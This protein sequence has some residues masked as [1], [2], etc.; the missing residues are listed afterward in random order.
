MVETELTIQGKRFTSEIIIRI[1]QESALVSRSRLSRLVCEWVNWK[2]SDGRP[3]EVG[4][5]KALNKLSRQGLI[6]LPQ[7]GPTI[8]AYKLPEV[9][10][11]STVPV[12]CN[13]NELKRI[14]V[15]P[16]ATAAE[17]GLWNEFMVR[18]HYLGK[19]GLVGSQR[20]YLI[21]SERGYL[22]GL[23]FSS[24][25]WAVQDRDAWI[26]WSSQARQAHLNHIVSNSRFLILPWVHVPHLAS[27]VLSVA[28]KRLEGDWQETYGYK[29]VLVET[30]VERERFVG[31]CYR[32]AGW[33]EVGETTGRGRQDKN[34][35]ATIPVKK[36]FLKPLREDF[37]DVLCVEPVGTAPL[38]SDWAYEE[39][40]RASL[41]DK[42]LK[43]RLIT[44]AQDFYA[45]PD[46]NIPKSSGSRAKTKATYRFLDH[47]DVTMKKILEPHYEAT[48]R[49]CNR[50]KVVL[51]IQDTTSFNY[52][53]HPDTEGLGLISRHA[54]GAVGILLHETLTVNP[55]GVSLGLLDAQS[56]V[57]DPADYGK[58][59]RRRKLPT[60]EKESYKWLKSFK[61]VAKFQ[62]RLTQTTLV[63]VG[64]REA[65]VYELFQ[66]AK[67]RP[68]HP[69][70]LV[71]AARNRALSDDQKYLWE[72]VEAQPVAGVQELQV[73]RRKGQKA[74]LARLEIRHSEVSLK[75]PRHR[76]C[77]TGLRTITVHAI[78]AKETDTPEGQIPLEWMLL[79]TLEVKNL[80]GAIEKLKWYSLRWQIE[81]YHKVLKTGINIEQRQLGNRDRIENCLAIDLVVAWR[82]L[83]LTKLGRETPDVPCTVV[84]ED[85][86]WKALFV[87]VNRTR[88]IPTTPPTLREAMRAV[89]GLGGFLGRKGDGEP[90][91]QTLWVGLQRLDDIAT[92]WQIFVATMLPQ[93]EL[94]VPSKSDYG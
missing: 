77:R 48:A 40:A 54:N 3:R 42:R 15:V 25:A 93:K 8:P 57:R 68:E 46:G 86:E 64:D 36:I 62:K 18:W 84:F 19:T 78:L 26:G 91:P 14:E 39:F 85:F 33:T 92:A 89:A 30:F 37:R 29:P 34:R 13:L 76:N 82:V 23:S 80:D 60:E 22:G 81:V 53:T 87:F 79:T 35:T 28:I 11:V 90:G 88:E 73:P 49:R 31:T 12:L 71:R 70:L 94:P 1:Q 5:R 43:Q 55:Q 51:A 65:D 74:R 7:A 20:R 56:W 32:A 10:S 17:R 67:S 50:E 16:V 58:K 45:R 47:G 52:Q 9:S 44:I 21:S 83:H 69:K 59:E 6:H 4:C 63:S 41:G 72:Y 27:H 75:P 38:F 66:F 2:T 24:A 61:A